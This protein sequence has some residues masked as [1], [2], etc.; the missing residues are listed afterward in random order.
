[1]IL[2]PLILTHGWVDKLFVDLS[3]SK[4]QVQVILQLILCSN[5]RCDVLSVLNCATA[6][7]ERLD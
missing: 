5:L 6:T 2:G 1:M 4:E 3:T 7:T